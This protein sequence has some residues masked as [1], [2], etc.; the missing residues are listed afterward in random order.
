MR[1]RDAKLLSPQIQRKYLISCHMP[2]YKIRERYLSKMTI[3]KIIT[4]PNSLHPFSLLMVSHLNRAAWIVRL[5]GQL[6]ARRAKPVGGLKTKLLTQ[7]VTEKG[8]KILAHE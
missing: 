5:R 1:H 3:Y 4:T 8:E 2:S 7:R 6:R